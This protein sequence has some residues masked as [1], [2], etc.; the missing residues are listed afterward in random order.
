MGRRDWHTFLGVDDHLSANAHTHLTH[1]CTHT[2]M[3]THTCTHTLTRTHGL[4]GESGSRK[5]GSDQEKEE[6][7][8]VEA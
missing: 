3:H 7:E 5:S 6:E 8:R 4:T 2:H 1:T